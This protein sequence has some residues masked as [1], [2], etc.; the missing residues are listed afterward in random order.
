MPRPPQRLHERARHGLV[1]RA[2]PR[3]HAR[4]AR[5]ELRELP[6]HERWQVRDVRDGVHGR[7][8]RRREPRV[9]RLVSRRLFLKVDLCQTR[10][11]VR[12]VALRELLLGLEQ[13]RERLECRRPVG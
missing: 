11:R 4:L 6:P 7:R 13:L 5:T 3:R 8:L 9:R 12:L 2:E 1:R 10:V